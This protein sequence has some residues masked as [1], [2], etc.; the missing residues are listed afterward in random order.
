VPPECFVS[1][2][3]GTICTDD[4]DV[5]STCEWREEYACYRSAT[6]ARQADAMCGWTD[7]AE[8]RECLMQL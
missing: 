6:C 1:G 5:A 4:P 7:T 3:S 8:L 2:C